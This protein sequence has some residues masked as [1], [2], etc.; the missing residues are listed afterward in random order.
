[1]MI[2]IK[3]EVQNHL[4]TNQELQ[5]QVIQMNKYKVEDKLNK[6]VDNW[7]SF[8]NKQLRDIDRTFL[9]FS[10][11]MS[12]TKLKKQSVKIQSHNKII[13]MEPKVNGEDLALS[14]NIGLISLIGDSIDCK[15][16]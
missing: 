8:K 16:T 6:K 11:K 15:L 2:L 9:T 3:I 1:M 5:V 10:E 14:T 12:K 13:T 7:M 4:Q